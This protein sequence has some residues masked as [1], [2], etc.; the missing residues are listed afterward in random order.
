MHESY[1][2]S[3]P[4]HRG[5]NKYPVRLGII[6]GG[7][8]ARMTAIAALPLGVEVVV[9]EKNPHSPAARLSPDCIVG[10]W[11][12]R[13]TLLRFAEECSVITLENEFVDA[14]ALEVLEKAGHKVF[15][16]SQCI[17]VTQ[18]K[19][20]QKS[21]LHKAGIA[22]PKFCAVKSPEEVVAAGNDFG[23][24]VVLKTRRNGYDGKGNFTLKSEADVAAGWQALGGDKNELMVEAW[25]S[26][27]KELAVIV[28][29]GQDGVTAVYPVVETIQRNH[30]CHVVKAPAPISDELACRAA[31]LA[32]RAIE[33]VGGVGSFGVEMFLSA[34]GELAINELA[35]RV[36][37]SG[38]YTIEAC[39]CSQFE[40]HVRA[41]LGWPLGNPEMIARAAVMV[42][43]LGTE[44]CS[45][46]PNGLDA[47]LRLKG[48]RVHLYGKASSGPGRKMGHITVRGDFV[49]EAQA[50]AERAAKEIYFGDLS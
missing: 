35:P 43:L 7:Q 9:L 17:A 33:A 48:V 38:H 39:D 10:D 8:L 3:L 26:F 28:T 13:E 41:V 25:F 14:G 21:A 20:A 47:A 22:V 42:N 32:K 37:N 23:W 4:R 24:P 29:R 6:G 5:K 27:V 1:D 15:P 31:T 46:E 36:H 49:D 2:P 11:A 16:S 45:G 12:D 18:D 40:N 34:T 50:I 44:K 19:F 30:V